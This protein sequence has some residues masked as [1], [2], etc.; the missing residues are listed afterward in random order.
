MPVYVNGVEPYELRQS[1]LDAKGDIVVGSAADTAARLAVGANG[2]TLMGSSASSAGL[3]YGYPSMVSPHVLA[4]TDIKAATFDPILVNTAG[5][6]LADGDLG[7]QSIY[8]PYP[9]TITGVGL[10]LVTQGD[11]TADNENR[12]GLYT[13]D[14]TNLTLVASTAD[15]GTFWEAS[16]GNVRKALSAPYV[17]AAGRYW[18]GYLSNWSAVATAPKIGAATAPYSGILAHNMSDTDEKLTGFVTAG[19]VTT[20]SS[21]IAWSGVSVAS[22]PKYFFLY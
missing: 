15:S 14:G 6:T 16:A 22:T 12:L 20:L 17:A 21:T 7:L 9:A 18:V 3:A 8:L 10:V 11:T 13:S 19:G 4:S 5:A 2:Q 1:V